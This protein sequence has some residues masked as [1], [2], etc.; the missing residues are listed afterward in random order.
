MRPALRRLSAGLLTA[1]VLIFGFCLPTGSF[2]LWDRNSDGQ[3]TTEPLQLR[4]VGRQTLNICHMLHMAYVTDK[5]TILTRGKYLT[6][7]TAFREAAIALAPLEELD[8]LRIQWDTCT[9]QDYSIAFCISS[10]DLSKRMTLW[11]LTVATQEG[12]VMRISMED[13]TATVLGFSYTDT[14]RP[15]HS[16]QSPPAPV[17]NMGRTLIELFADY[18]GVCLGGTTVVSGAGG[19]MVSVTDESSGLATEIPYALDKTGI[20]VN[21][22]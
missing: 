2:A 14:A 19:Y 17:Q 6:P 7:E 18:W 4:T 22:A 11:T 15:L 3:I 5:T 12:A 8:F 1:A 13:Q 20:R 10:E 16:G 21:I 9:L